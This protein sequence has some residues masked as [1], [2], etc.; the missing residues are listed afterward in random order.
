M[1]DNDFKYNRDVGEGDQ[2]WHKLIVSIATF[3]VIQYAQNM[4]HMV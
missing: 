1:V 3:A 2:A 4:G